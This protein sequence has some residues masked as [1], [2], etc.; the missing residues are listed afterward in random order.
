LNEKHIQEHIEF[1]KNHWIYNDEHSKEEEEV[2][3]TCILIPYLISKK[4][5][6][7]NK[8]PIV[9]INYMFDNTGILSPVDF[10]IVEPI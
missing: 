3:N 5:K 2:Y 9:Y 7:K 1:N 10:G 8:P 6:Q 4:S